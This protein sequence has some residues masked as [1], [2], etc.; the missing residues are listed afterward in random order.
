METSAAE[1][2]ERVY[3]TEFNTNNLGRRRD[4]SRSVETRTGF[5]KFFD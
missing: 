5:S 1:T 2:R 3:L 4:F